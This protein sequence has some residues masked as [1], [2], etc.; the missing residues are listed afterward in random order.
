[1]TPSTITDGIKQAV[2]TRLA[3]INSAI[4]LLDLTNGKPATV[5]VEDVLATAER[6]ELWAW[7]GL[8]SGQVE[9]PVLD[10]SLGPLPPIPLAAGL[11]PHAQT[12]GA[13]PRHQQYVR[14]SNLAERAF[15][16]ER[17]RT[18]VIPQLW[19]EGGLVKLVFAVLSRVSERW[20]KKCF[21][22]FEEQ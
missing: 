10:T 17:R 1:M 3:T 4:A 5:A 11:H 22:E 12:N 6:I 13:P 20:G 9:T 15:E 2:I 7:R 19:T 21:S 8:A 14:T 16:E 18:K